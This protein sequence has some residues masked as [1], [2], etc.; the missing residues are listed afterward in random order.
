MRENGQ[1]LSDPDVQLGRNAWSERA[2]KLANNYKNQFEL[3]VLFYAVAA[4]LLITSGVD[5]LMVAL[6][7][8]F[9]LSRIAQTAI[10]IGPNVVIWRAAAFL[11]GVV[12]LVAMW[13]KLTLHIL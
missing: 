7:W 4:F 5:D 10:H 13:V 8:V 1:K 9:V 2:T 3:P 12:A 6:A 11:V